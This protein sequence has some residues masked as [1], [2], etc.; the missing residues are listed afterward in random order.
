M[1][2][3]PG[4][5]KG[6]PKSG[7]RAKGTPNRATAELRQWL[8]KLIKR[9]RAQI[10]SDL[11]TIEPRERLIMLEKLMQYVVP[12]QAAITADIALLTDEELTTVATDILNSLNN[13][14]DTTNE[15]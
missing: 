9:N 1:A 2:N 5:P 11:A 12:K 15:R 3:K 7:G 10:V 4:R 13:D 6:Y 8:A 14:D